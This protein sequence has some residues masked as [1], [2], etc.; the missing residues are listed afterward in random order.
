MSWF[1]QIPFIDAASVGFS[2]AS[3]AWKDLNTKYRI[4]ALVLLFLTISFV[5]K[6]KV[7]VNVA[8]DALHRSQ[9]LQYIV[10]G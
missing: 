1:T 3:K 7:H 4:V 10:W 8:C 5:I 6:R 2:I 9:T